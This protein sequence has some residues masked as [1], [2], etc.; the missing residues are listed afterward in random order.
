[1]STPQTESKRNAGYQ[2]AGMVEDGMVVGLGTGSTVF[3]AMERLGERIRRDGLSI[4]GVPTSYQ[5]AIR[6]R[7]YGIPLTSLDEHPEI[8]IAIDGA[9]QVDPAGNL[10]K[11]RGA[12]LLREKCVA[13]AARRVIIVVDPTKMVET[14]DAL[15]PVEVLPFASTSVSR[16]LSLLG[17]VPTMREGVKKDGPVVTDNGNFIL[18]C[19][20]G[21]IGSPRDLEAKIAAIPGALECGLFT[22]YGEKITV[23]VGEEKGCRVVSLR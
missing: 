1:M 8:D 11:G 9:D 19:S 3:F 7:E 16:R 12:A 21:T 10:I 22:A 13:D 18:D 20:F 14:F 5:A 2:A 23:I 4:A 15:V 6:A 17:A